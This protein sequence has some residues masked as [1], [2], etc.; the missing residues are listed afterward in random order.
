[1]L[2]DRIQNSVYYISVNNRA[3]DADFAS[4]KQSWNWS[5]LIFSVRHLKC[6]DQD[7]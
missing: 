3:N 6:K 4:E 7:T 1:M 5:F 2:N